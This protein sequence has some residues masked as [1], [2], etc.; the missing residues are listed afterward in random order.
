MLRLRSR[1]APGQTGKQKKEMRV[2]TLRTPVRIGNVLIVVARE[3]WMMMTAIGKRMLRE[4][5]LREEEG[6]IL[7]G[8]R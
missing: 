5:L 4:L 7:Y 1:L 8:E 6:A 2:E 3:H